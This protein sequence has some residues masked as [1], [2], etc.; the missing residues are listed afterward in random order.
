[1]GSCFM[2]EPVRQASRRGWRSGG[3]QQ[4]PRDGG[5]RCKLSH[6]MASPLISGSGDVPAPCL[7]AISIFWSSLAHMTLVGQVC[8]YTLHTSLGVPADC[9]TELTEMELTF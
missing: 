4:Q 6:V 5:Q 1:M 7:G 3:G 8:A 2:G 9:C